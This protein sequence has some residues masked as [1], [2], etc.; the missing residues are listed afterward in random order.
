MDALNRIAQLD[1]KIAEKCFLLN[2]NLKRFLT[3]FEF[4]Y[5]GIPWFVISGFV[6]LFAQDVYWKNRA[7]IFI[8]GKHDT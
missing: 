3:I 8:L 1:K 4:V 2:A 6:Y 5:N 7:L